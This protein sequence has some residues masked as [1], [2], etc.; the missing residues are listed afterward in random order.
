MRY[1]FKHLCSNSQIST[2]F[3][4][5]DL[6]VYPKNKKAKKLQNKIKIKIGYPWFIQRL[7]AK[8]V[9]VFSELV[10]KLQSIFMCLCLQSLSSGM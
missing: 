9:D 8:K 4:V 6:T 2:F 3:I 7:S 5:N 1:C 10:R